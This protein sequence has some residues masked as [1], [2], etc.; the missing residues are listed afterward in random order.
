MMI[1]IITNL[2]H[3]IIE[4]R[5]Y[6]F[7]GVLD[8]GYHSLSNIT[9]QHNSIANNQYYGLL[10]GSSLGGEVKKFNSGRQHG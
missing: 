5:N 3:L 8:G 6:Y 4:Q 2:I 10:I 9:Y 1:R 7:T